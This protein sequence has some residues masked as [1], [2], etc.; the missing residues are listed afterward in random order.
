MFAA[1]IVRL[2]GRLSTNEPT[3]T[4]V[5]ETTVARS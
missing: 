1:A 3:G 2:N 4:V 5:D